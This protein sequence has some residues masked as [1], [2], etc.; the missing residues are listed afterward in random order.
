MKFCQDIFVKKS[1]IVEKLII[2]Y[3]IAYSYNL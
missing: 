2:I 3:I 1:K